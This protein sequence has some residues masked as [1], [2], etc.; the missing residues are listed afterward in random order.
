M[1]VTECIGNGFIVIVAYLQCFNISCQ[2][3]TLCIQL[4]SSYENVLELTYDDVKLQK[5]LKM[6]FC[7]ITPGPPIKGSVTDH[8]RRTC[9]QAS[10]GM[11]ASVLAQNKST[12]LFTKKVHCVCLCS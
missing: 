8:A 4:V 6:F 12:N 9:L 3:K 11:G 1:L 5:M 2:Y 7:G 10:G